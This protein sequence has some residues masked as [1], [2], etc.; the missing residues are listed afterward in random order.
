MV[1]QHMLIT[2]RVSL[3]NVDSRTARLLMGLAVSRT[4]TLFSNWHKITLVSRLPFGSFQKLPF[5]NFSFFFPYHLLGS[6][7]TTDRSNSVSLTFQQCPKTGPSHSFTR[8]LCQS[9]LV[10]LSKAFRAITSALLVL[11]AFGSPIPVLSLFH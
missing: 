1:D 8:C 5:T 11:F 3:S 9:V 6:I 4:Q 7:L 2:E 10:H